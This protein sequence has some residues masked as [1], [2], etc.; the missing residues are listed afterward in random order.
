MP[1]ARAPRRRDHQHTVTGSEIDQA[2]VR[3]EVRMVEHCFDE[4]R[5]R[6]HPLDVFARLVELRLV[7]L[8]L[9]RSGGRHRP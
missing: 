6:G 1:R 3:R 8:C 7:R 9:L 4:R 2:V 5:R